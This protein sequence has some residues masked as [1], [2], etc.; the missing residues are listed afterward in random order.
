MRDGPA[1]SARALIA[2]AGRPPR[3]RGR[4]C[5]RPPCSAPASVFVSAAGAHSFPNTAANRVR[6]V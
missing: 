1:G 6:A 3:G 4:V 2:A 5:R